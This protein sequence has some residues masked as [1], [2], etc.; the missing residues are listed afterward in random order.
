MNGSGAEPDA[1][2]VTSMGLIP[3]ITGSTNS[4]AWTEMPFATSGA[5]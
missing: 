1:S 3:E 4:L 5:K 2:K